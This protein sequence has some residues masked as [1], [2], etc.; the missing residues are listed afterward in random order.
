MHVTVEQKVDALL[1]KHTKEQP[2]KV[3]FSLG[4][5]IHAGRIPVGFGAARCFW[6]GRV[7]KR[8]TGKCAYGCVFAEVLV[9]ILW[10]RSKNTAQD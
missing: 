6:F 5:Q 9:T 2:V 4:P 7:T 8:D 1:W 3:D 10:E